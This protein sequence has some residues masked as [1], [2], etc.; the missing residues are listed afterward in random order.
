MKDFKPAKRLKR[1]DLI[2]QTERRKLMN[3]F[4]R[5]LK[6][7]ERVNLRKNAENKRNP[8]TSGTQSDNGKKYIPKAQLEYEA[9]KKEK[10]AK[11]EVIL[12]LF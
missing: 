1:K 2:A 8:G 5:E 9:K 10:E 12:D 4:K 3:R 11:L 7:S 6:P